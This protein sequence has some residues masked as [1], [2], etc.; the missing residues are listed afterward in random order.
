LSK[1]MI[2][3]QDGSL[4]GFEA[5]NPVLSLPKNVFVN[6]MLNCKHILPW[7]LLFK[8]TLRPV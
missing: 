6:L 5:R 2:W 7:R 1:A 8:G 3:C 4:A